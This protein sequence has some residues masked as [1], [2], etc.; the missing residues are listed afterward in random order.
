MRNVGFHPLLSQPPGSGGDGVPGG[1]L[2]LLLS[3]GGWEQDSWVERLPR[4]LEPMGVVSLR[5][6]NGKHAATVIESTPIHIAIVDLALPLD[7]PEDV[8]FAEGG[9]RL[10]ELLARL[11]QP[12]PTV[13][14]RRSRT[15]R[16]DTRELNAALRAGAY[17]VV[18]RPS[19]THELNVMLEVLR[20]CLT[21]FYAGRWPAGA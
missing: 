7:R 3:H 11:S 8:E 21:R 1:R 10:L 14:V 20:R 12:P 13:V 2:N 16:D 17:A 6:Q 5:A 18:D 15:H 19:D 4:L 9:V